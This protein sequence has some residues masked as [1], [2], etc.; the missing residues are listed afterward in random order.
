MGPEQNMSEAWE[1][2]TKFGGLSICVRHK[3]YKYPQK[4]YTVVVMKH[5]VINGWSTLKE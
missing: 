5:D 4:S 3:N 2:V 1:I